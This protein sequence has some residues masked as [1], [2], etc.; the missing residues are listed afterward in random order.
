[1]KVVADP[2]AF[3]PSRPL[4]RLG[5]YAALVRPRIAVMVLVTVTLGGLLAADSLV[6]SWVL[7]HAVVATALVTASASIL[8]QWLECATDA[9]MPR[10]ANRPL[11]SGRV[12]PR[13]AF[14]LGVVTAALGFAYMLAAVPHALA[15]AVTAFTFA[16]Y[17]FAYTPLKTRTTLNTLVG[18]VPGAMPPVI[19][20]TSVTGTLDAGAVALFLIVF[21]WQIPHFLAIAWRYRDEY[22]R[23]GLRMLPVGDRTGDRTAQQM[24]LYALALVP[25]SLVPVQI[26]IAGPM[27]AVVAGLFGALFLW[28]I[29]RFQKERSVA[30][31]RRVLRA[32]LVYLPGVLV[33]LLLSKFW[34]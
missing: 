9:Q 15:T 23:A 5:D 8:N 31:A 6:P 25:V 20:W 26:G 24:L 17:V 30:V 18:A 13:E 12:V 19:G 29:G 16:S 28:P 21:V 32:S 22:G 34:V 14:V 27:Y 33:A 2:L 11:P 4:A 7:I 10:T 3:A 1:M